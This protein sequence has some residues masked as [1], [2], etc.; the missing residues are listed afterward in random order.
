MKNWIHVAR[1]NDTPG[2]PI[3]TST[4]YKWFRLQ[5]YP[6][7]FKKIG[8]KLFIDLDELYALGEASSK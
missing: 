8:G 7:V 5:K 2:S 6:K 4:A 1:L 3:R